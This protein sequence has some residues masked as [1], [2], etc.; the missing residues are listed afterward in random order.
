[1]NNTN[2]YNVGGDWASKVASANR[3][4]LRTLK[5]AKIVINKPSGVNSSTIT[6]AHNLGFI[7]SV[8]AYG[9]TDN[10]TF[11]RLPINT[12]IAATYLVNVNMT[13][14]E[15]NIYFTAN[16]V[17]PSLSLSSPAYTAYVKYFIFREKV[18]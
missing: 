11:Q 3:Q 14:D 8:I 15:I 2:I 18:K 7:P 12:D 5:S 10:V 17:D 6:V 4:N 1:M 16:V 9:S 13:I